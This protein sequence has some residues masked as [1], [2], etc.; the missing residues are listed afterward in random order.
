M[1]NKQ[2]DGVAM[3][4]PF[5]P[6]LENTFLSYHEKSWSKSC[7]QGFKPI[8]YR[9][10]VDIIFV[11]FKSNDRLKYFQEFLISCHINMS[12]SVETERQN[13]FSF[14]IIREQGKFSTTIYRKPTFSGVYSVYREN[15]INKYL[16]KFLDNINL[17]REKVPAVEIK[18]L[19]LVLPYLWVISLQT[20]IKLKEVIKSI[21]ICCKL[22]IAFKYQTKLS[23]SFWFKYP[24][25]K[26]FIS[27]VV[28]KSQCGLWN[29]SYYGESIRHLDIRSGEH[30]VESPLT[31]KKEKPIKNSAVHDHR[32]HC[33]YLPSFDNFGI[34]AHEN[35]KV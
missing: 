11:L 6:S 10:H 16:I 35:N 13:K 17:V 18:R 26:D 29:E 12:F 20:R 34:L 31:G 4:S 33:N 14:E 21:L 30:K 1:L 19:L 28:Y 7:P 27:G 25:P 32:L 24:I 23:N 15:V 9:R 2:T 3:G 22:E 5:G 8:F